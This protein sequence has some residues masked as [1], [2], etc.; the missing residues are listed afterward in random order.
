MGWVVEVPIDLAHAICPDLP[1]SLPAGV[2]VGSV[3]KCDHPECGQ[4]WRV[5]NLFPTTDGGQCINWDGPLAESDL[6]VS[7]VQPIVEPSTKDQK[8]TP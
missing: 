7:S 6:D 4:S 2:G 8:E 3:W 5:Q 1:L